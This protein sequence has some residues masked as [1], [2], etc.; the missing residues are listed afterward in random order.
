[1]SNKPQSISTNASD[2]IPKKPANVGNP[3]D[4]ITLSV[5]M[6]K[7]TTTADTKGERKSSRHMPLF[8]EPLS[9]HPVE[10]KVAA[11][12]AAIEAGADVN[13]LDQE[14]IV[15]YNEGRP[16][17]ACING[18]H[19][20]SGVRLEDNIPAIE[21]LL[22]H[23]ADPRLGA[24]PTLFAPERR[25]RYFVENATSEGGKATWKRILAMFDVAIL[26]LDGEQKNEAEKAYL[27]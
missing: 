6:N 27:L 8:R 23:G 25:A 26:R 9:N 13:Q 20:P 17:D 5:D 4:S 18:S 22:Q 1:M 14:P 10:E 16:L 12:R 3:A 19:M 7:Y 2:D 11:M 24:R 21:L 15:G